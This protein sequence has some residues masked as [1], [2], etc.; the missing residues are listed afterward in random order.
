MNEI[1]QGFCRWLNLSTVEAIVLSRDHKRVLNELLDDDENYEIISRALQRWHPGEF[2]RD[3]IK[4][5]IE[6]LIKAK[7]I[8]CIHEYFDAVQNR[9]NHKIAEEY[10]EKEFED[11]WFRITAQGRHEL[12]GVTSEDL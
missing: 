10:D 12:E 7:H 4:E 5:N 3:K 8:V 1:G 2:D 11:Y 9:Y 6:A